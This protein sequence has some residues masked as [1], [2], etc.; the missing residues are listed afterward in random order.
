[1]TI[2]HRPEQTNEKAL[3]PKD[4]DEQPDHEIQDEHAGGVL[5]VSRDDAERNLPPDRDPDDPVSP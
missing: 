2:S 5:K 1:M 3:R 4:E